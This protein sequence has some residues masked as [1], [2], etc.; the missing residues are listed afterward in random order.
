VTAGHGGDDVIVHRV[1]VVTDTAEPSPSLT[2]AVR[3][4]AES[5]DAQFRLVV[6]NPARAELHLL[7]PERHD[8]ALEAEAVLLTTIPRLE[9]VV[10]AQVIGS[11]SV[12][13]DPMDAIEETLFN[14]PIDEILIDVPMHRLSSFLHQDLEH[15]LAHLHIPVTTIRHDHSHS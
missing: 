5:H 11:V 7:H 8:K 9:T 13:H 4:R 14:E 1:L 3:H 6:L 15:R 2:D 12:R 10:G